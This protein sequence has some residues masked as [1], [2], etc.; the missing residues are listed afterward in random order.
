MASA[1]TGGD[2]FT[3]SAAD[4]ENA[5][6]LA[7][8]VRKGNASA[9]VLDAHPSVVIDD[10]SHKYV[11]I[12]ARTEG[13]TKM[14]VRMTAGAPYH[15]DVAKPYVNALRAAGVDADVPGGGRI[16]HDPVAKTINIFG[17]SYGFGKANHAISADI[18]RAHFGNEYTVTWSDEGY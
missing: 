8:G 11:L 17:F 7:A 5:A 6:A 18:C 14:L 9:S 12:S 13:Q 2:G 1:A 15:A 3:T 16:A 4:Q 10:G